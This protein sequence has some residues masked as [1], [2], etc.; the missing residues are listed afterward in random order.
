M[1][2]WGC[3]QRCNMRNAICTS[4]LYQTEVSKASKIRKLAG[5]QPPF[6]G[7]AEGMGF[8]PTIRLITV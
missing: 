6:G 5:N 2:D 7:L 1:P 4:V 8:E 3:F